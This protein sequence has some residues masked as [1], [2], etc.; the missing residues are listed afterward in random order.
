M[1]DCGSR[2]TTIGKYLKKKKKKKLQVQPS[3]A[4]VLTF[5]YAEFHAVSIP[6]SLSFSE[7]RLTQPLDGLTIDTNICTML[8]WDD[9]PTTGKVVVEGEGS[10]R[11]DDTVNTGNNSKKYWII[12]VKPEQKCRVFGRCK[13]WLCLSDIPS[14]AMSTGNISDWSPW[15][16]DA[17]YNK[18]GR[19]RWY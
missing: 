15:V 8:I 10:L 5:V 4:N 3:K 6:S 2:D 11:V 9:G 13:F 14:V 7:E 12:L 16:W 19:Y 17:R 18:F 1:G